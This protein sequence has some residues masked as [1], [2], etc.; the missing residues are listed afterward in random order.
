M[1]Q[2]LNQLGSGLSLCFH[3]FGL[4][5]CLEQLSEQFGRKRI[6]IGFAHFHGATP[7]GTAVFVIIAYLELI[8]SD[9]FLD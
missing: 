4:G 3:I 8:F 7:K 1:C 9:W 6:A 2:I 5:R